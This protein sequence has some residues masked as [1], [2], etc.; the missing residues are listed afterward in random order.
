MG[1]RGGGCHASRRMERVADVLQGR[2]VMVPRPDAED[3]DMQD[4]V[5]AR[6]PGRTSEPR[7]RESTRPRRSGVD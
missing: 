7:P 5:N 6:L 4:A 1:R 3:L 2:V